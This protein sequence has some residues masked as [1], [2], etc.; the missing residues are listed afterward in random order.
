LATLGETARRPHY[1]TLAFAAV[2]SGVAAFPLATCS[3]TSSAP[4]PSAANYP[5]SHKSPKDEVNEG[6][7]RVLE[8]EATA[9]IACHLR[10]LSDL[11]PTRRDPDTF[12]DATCEITETFRGPLRQGAAH[13]VWQ[14][15]RGNPMPPPDAELLVFLK[16]RTKPLDDAP[17][18]E[19]V[20]LDTGVLRYVPKLQERMRRKAHHK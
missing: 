14:V 13:F 19:W 20:A 4:A 5:V 6:L 16:R 3:A 2:I 8:K 18:L 17:T 7:V 10:G 11:F 12:Y 15:E 9:I 1:R